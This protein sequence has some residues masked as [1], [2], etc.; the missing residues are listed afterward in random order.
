MAWFADTYEEA[1]AAFREE[2]RARGGRLETLAVCPGADGEEGLTTDAAI[3]GEDHQAALCVSSGTHGIE[4]YA[5]SA[6]Q[7]Q[8]MADGWPDGVRVVLVHA[9]NPFG[10]A[11]IRRVNENNVDL[12]RNFLAA[13]EN[14]AG[15]SDGYRA[16]QGLL[17]PT[18]PAGGFEAFLPRAL[19]SI[20][21]HG[22]P[23]L[24][25]AVAGGQYDFPQGL[26]WG[27]DQLQRGPELLLEALP[28]WM[29]GADPIVHIDVHTGLGRSGEY[30]L[31]VEAEAGGQRCQDLRDAFGTRV[32][33]WDSAEGVAYAI[34]GGFPSAI[35]RVLG[36][37]VDV[38]TQE[39]GTLPSIKVLEALRAENRA[40]HHGGDVAGAK[41]LLREAFYPRSARWRRDI[42]AGGRAVLARAFTR[43]GR[44]AG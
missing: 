14:Y 9:V 38:L 31:L 44:S 10:M 39:F 12:N 6:I 21:R 7:R 32:Q 4:G 1:R 13:G 23:K 22:M 11:K 36:D 17:N 33:P 35:E 40:H 41:A 20:L 2:A 8:L 28:R 34:R 30:A 25:Q 42:L 29:D 27:G 5:G 16:L 3:F 24:R 15:S 18:S 37:R 43:I 26:F 19:W